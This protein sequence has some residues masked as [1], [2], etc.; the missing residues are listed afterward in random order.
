MFY[1]EQINRE[2]KEHICY[3][4]CNTQLQDNH[5]VIQLIELTEEEHNERMLLQEEL[6]RI[7]QEDEDTT[8]EEGE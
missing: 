2:T 3:L 1:Y 5:P 7:L 6:N 8:N 4:T